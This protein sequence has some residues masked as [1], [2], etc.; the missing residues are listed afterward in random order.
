MTDTAGNRRGQR[1]VGNT[2]QVV[3]GLILGPIAVTALLQGLPIE[4]GAVVLAVSVV[5]TLAVAGTVAARFRPGRPGAIAFAV[6]A[7]LV[8]VL[9]ALVVLDF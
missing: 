4:S 8:N 2:L 7:T 5:A 6:S 9:V 1:A 3:A